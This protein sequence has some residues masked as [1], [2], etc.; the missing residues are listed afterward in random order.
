SKGHVIPAHQILV[1]PQVSG[2]IEKLMIEEGRRVQKGDVLAVL[3]STDYTA[4]HDRSK[5]MLRVSQ[6][7]L[8]ELTKGN[9]PEEIEQCR[10][11][12]KE[13][14]ENIKQL[15]LDVERNRK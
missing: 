9:R 15:T 8:K 7:K 11:E 4:D 5:A 12:L 10:Y 6:E 2:R 1:S 3:E 14:E 13:T